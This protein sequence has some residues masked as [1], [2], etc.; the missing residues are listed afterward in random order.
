[1]FPLFVRRE[2][3]AAESA[4]PLADRQQAPGCWVMNKNA[5]KTIV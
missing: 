3:T 1:M 4:K 2:F 5:V